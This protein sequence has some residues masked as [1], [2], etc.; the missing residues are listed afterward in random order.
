VQGP[1]ARPALMKCIESDV[2]DGM[3]ASD[4]LVA[5]VSAEVPADL[6]DPA[7]CRELAARLTLHARE[8]VP[9]WKL[10]A[11]MSCLT[12][13][14]WQ[15]WAVYKQH[16]AWDW[17]Q[18]CLAG[19]HA[20]AARFPAIAAAPISP[21]ASSRSP[22]RFALDKIAEGTEIG[23]GS[24]GR[25]T[26]GSPTGVALTDQY[27][28]DL[29]S[30]LSP[31]AATFASKVQRAGPRSHATASLPGEVT[32]RA[33]VLINKLPTTSS[34]EA[35]FTSPRIRSDVDMFTEALLPLW[36]AREKEL[37]TRSGHGAGGA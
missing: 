35:P 6:C 20:A 4:V 7:I 17:C 23:S 28:R 32:T 21:T 8:S 34:M 24:G 18:Y 9:T 10:Q 26:P 1:C 5:F 12:Y 13:A 30:A 31:D 27:K 16:L 22:S 29:A 33:A 15:Q 25:G 3:Y 19:E 37:S 14:D 2:R 36:S 11:I